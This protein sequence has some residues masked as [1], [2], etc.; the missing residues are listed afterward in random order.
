MQD[1]NS[2]LILNGGG[3]RTDDKPTVTL[4]TPPDPNGTNAFV[5]VRVANIQKTS[6]HS[7]P[8]SPLQRP[9]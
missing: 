6:S 8:V 4:T 1:A 5:N 9:R 7:N 2:W 3:H